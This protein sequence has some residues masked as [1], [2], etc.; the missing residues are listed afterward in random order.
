MIRGA[1]ADTVIEVLH[2]TQKKHDT[3]TE[4]TLNMANF[5][6]LI[7]GKC[8]VNPTQITDRYHIQKLVLYQFN[9]LISLILLNL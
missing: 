6:K 9:F 5:M 2:K 7:T 8:F 4:M 1:K 3:V